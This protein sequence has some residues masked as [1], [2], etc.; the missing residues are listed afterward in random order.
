ME[1]RTSGKRSTERPRQKT[2]DWM[3]DKVNEKKPMAIL[4]KKLSGEKSGDT[5][6]AFVYL[7]SSSI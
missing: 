7:S 4:K 5:E 2:L 1:G 3:I 6:H